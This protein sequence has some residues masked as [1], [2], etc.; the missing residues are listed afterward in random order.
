MEADPLA[1]YPES[2]HLLVVLCKVMRIIAI[3]ADWVILVSNASEVYSRYR[4]VLD[5]AVDRDY[6]PWLPSQM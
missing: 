1:P 2:L 6:F 5:E 4:M 3:E